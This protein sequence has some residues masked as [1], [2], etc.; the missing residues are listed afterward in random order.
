MSDGSKTPSGSNVRNRSSSFCKI[1]EIYL[2]GG[3]LREALHEADLIKD[4]K[5]HLRTYRSCIVGKDLIDWLVN[6]KHCDTRQSAIDGLLVLQQHSII[7]HVCDDHDIKD[8]VLFYRFRRD[9]GTFTEDKDLTLFYKALELYKG[10]SSRN[11]KVIKSYQQDGELFRNAFRGSEFVDYV[12]NEGLVYSRDEAVSIG[13]S[14]LEC[15]TIRHVTDDYH[16]RDDQRLLY[17]FTIDFSR[18]RYLSEVFNYVPRD[19]HLK[20]NNE[21]EAKHQFRFQTPPSSP[22]LVARQHNS[23]TEDS[24]SSRERRSSTTGSSDD[25]LRSL[26]GDS[27][28][29]TDSSETLIEK[30]NTPRSVLLRH[31]TVDELES[32]DTPYVKQTIKIPSDPV[33][34]GFVIRGDCPTYVQ[35]VDP[36]GPAARA[37]LKIRQYIYSVN[38]QYVLRTDHKSVGKLIMQCVSYVNM[39]VMTHKRD[40][41]M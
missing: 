3:Y 4:R 16:F 33:G 40:A 36:M 27:G 19:H 35:A 38:G 28:N 7:H 8:Q 32:P 14:L 29:G 2:I 25:R 5:Y 21:P 30:M 10:L 41:G 15:D 23:T 1:N 31:A 13:R 26:S 22:V 39:I 9:D 12:L 17:Q 34:Y 20:S 18:Q 6:N 37:G 11:K 24:D